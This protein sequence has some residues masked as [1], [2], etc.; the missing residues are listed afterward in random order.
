MSERTLPQ[1]HLRRWSGV[2]LAAMLLLGV[3]LA[4]PAQAHR[5]GGGDDD[6]TGL[7]I[8]LTNDDS[9]QAANARHSDGLGLYEVRRALCAQGAD[10]VV[11]A[12]WGVQSG[13][14]SA[15]TNS[16]SV[17]LGQKDAPDGYEADCATAPAGG[18]VYGLCLGTSPCDEDSESAT[19]TDTVMFATRGGLQATVGWHEPDLV[20]SGA[21]SG[22]NV[23]SSVNDSGTVGAAIAA[24]ADG[25]PAVAFSTQFAP[26]FSFSVDSYRATAQWGAQFMADL[27][28]RNL[29]LQSEF[30][31]NVN[32][33]D[34]SDG[35]TVQRPKWVQVGSAT[36]A[37]HGYTQ[38][39][40]GSWS[41][42]LSLCDGLGICEEGKRR[43]DWLALN[44]G[45]VTVTPITW[46]RTY[47]A[48]ERMSTLSKVRSFVWGYGR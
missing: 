18:A 38:Q 42:G 24:I 28:A 39:A 48:Y 31:L 30:A 40:D 19:P 36:V 5:Y 43:A 4:A 14:G 27:H 21:N 2:A 44:D 35:K 16:G 46:D 1:S 26:D 3:A 7:R 12:P 22:G 17:N 20:V 37:Y 41:I 45:H 13:R 25:L 6:L 29:L 10:V 15:V 8:L 9:M 47:G 32:H 23:A 34:I 33:P 11:I